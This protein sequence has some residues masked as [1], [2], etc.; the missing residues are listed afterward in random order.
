MSDSN[1]FV[2]G[3]FVTTG[4]KKPTPA[5]LPKE[6]SGELV[7]TGNK[8]SAPLILP[9]EI[10]KATTQA[11]VNVPVERPEHEMVRPSTPEEFLP[12]IGKWVVVG[13]S[14]MV[15]TFCGAIGLSSILK[16]KVTVQA[17]SAIRPIGELRLVQASIEGSVLNIPI[18]ENQVV[19][20]GDIM[21]TVRD[22]RLESKLK[23]KHSQLIGDLRKDKQQLSAL[24]VQIAALNRQGLGERDRDN[25]S[26]SA[27]QSELSRAE[28]EYLDKRATSQSKVAKAKANI[29]T[30]EKDRQVAETEL[31]ITTANLNS[32]RA[33]YEAAV[34][35]RDRYQTAR[36]DGAIAQN[37]L[38]EAQLSA[39][40][41]SQAIIAQTATI[42]KQQQTIDRLH[43]VVNSARAELTE[44]QTA[45]NPSRAEVE[46]IQHKI[47]REQATGKTTISRFQQEQQKLLQQRAEIIDRIAATKQ[48]IA[49]I[50]TELKPT[51]I[52]A[53]IA[54]TVQNLNLR[55]NAQVVHPGDRIAQII[56]NH[57]PITIKAN[58]AISDIGKVKVGQKVQMRV[59]ACPYTDN[60]VLPGQV[61]EI[62]ADA[63]SIDRTTANNPGQQS[64]SE[65]TGFY[66]VTVK[67]DVLTLGQGSNK[68][69]IRSGME[70]RADIISKEQTILQF[71]L[72][73]AR[74][75]V[76]P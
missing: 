66:E 47:A 71:V 12:A 34:A 15:A 67:P 36:K 60:G 45:L 52:V 25:R 13:G 55:N 59:S 44:V 46:Q 22:L 8:K 7:T 49:Q 74:L 51:P 18:R 57:T 39:E 24:D 32:T 37:Q 48:D 9:K 33:A 28:R 61:T 70:G 53:P 31:R 68:C 75:L 38:E 62:A 2:S 64:Q 65:A 63:K 40:Q 14:A 17:P 6:I 21:A 41:Q 26:I 50:A 42:T 69:Q 29:Q 23:T 27:I 43:S 54:G 30:A 11:L 4:N 19:K 20:R 35:K 73:K 10:V 3:E 5:I 58:V 1:F 72:S 76:D 16:Y 56:P